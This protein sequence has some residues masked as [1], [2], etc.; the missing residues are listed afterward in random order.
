LG[1]V[2]MLQKPLQYS[3]LIEV[4][5][6]TLAHPLGHAGL[7]GKPNPPDGTLR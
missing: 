3:R 7:R 1:F 6:E 4:I 2:G 5:R